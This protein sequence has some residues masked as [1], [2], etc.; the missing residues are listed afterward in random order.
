MN[1]CTLCE[2]ARNFGY[3]YLCLYYYNTW[4]NYTRNM[5]SNERLLDLGGNNTRST[6]PIKNRK[7]SLLADKL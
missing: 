3:M 1:L 5:N 7:C 2:Y 4:I 6:V